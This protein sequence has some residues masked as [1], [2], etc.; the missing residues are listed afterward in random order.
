[1]QGVERIGV[2]LD[3]GLLKAFDDLIGG[4]GYNNRSEAI[5]D[6]IRR[7][8]AEDKLADPNSQAVAAVLLV[9]DHHA[10]KLTDRLLHL[11]HS[12]LLETISSMHVH[13]D[14]HHCLE[15]IVLKGK[16]KEINKVG[17]QMVSLKGVK[18][19]RVN[20]MSTLD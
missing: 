14:H 17:D 20:I 19:G 4:K 18:L 12:H 15:M 7:D 11:Q 16:V 9:Y 10:S 13:L 3:Q 6:L 5:R 1:M 8:L 2:S